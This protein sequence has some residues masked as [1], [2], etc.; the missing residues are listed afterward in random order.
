MV[1]LDE[2]L[3]VVPLADPDGRRTCVGGWATSFCVDGDC[4]AWV[5][6]CTSRLDISTAS[7]IRAAID[8]DATGAIKIGRA[9][10]RRRDRGGRRPA[11]A[12]LLSPSPPAIAPSQLRLVE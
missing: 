10:P 7:L 11:G 12:L 4:A 8:Y 9:Q 3:H 1:L 2:R 6:A 5:D